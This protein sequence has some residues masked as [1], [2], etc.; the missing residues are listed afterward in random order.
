MNRKDVADLAGCTGLGALTA[1]GLLA[2][3]V[4]G[5]DG[6]VPFTDEDL[7]SWPLAHRPAVAVA[8]ARGLTATGTGVVPYVL[9]VLAGLVAARAVRGRLLAVALCVACL[10][11]GQAARYGVMRLTAR[12]RP[13]RA[14]WATHASGWSFP[15]GHATTATLTAGL[16]VV[17]VLARGPRGKALLALAACCWGALVGLTRVY[18]GVHWFTDVLGGWLFGVGWLGLCLAAVARW[19]PE[20]VIAGTG[21]TTANGTTDTTDTTEEVAE[22]APQDPGRRGRSRPA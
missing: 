8:L 5:G 2:L 13:P 6:A 1:F 9:A 10:G 17:A 16:L 11:T 12:P 3:V 22:H 7:H 15:S 21:D 14:E 4:V 20:Q 18:L 19:A